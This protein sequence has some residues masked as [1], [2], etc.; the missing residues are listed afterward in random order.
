LAGLVFDPAPGK[1]LEETLSVASVKELSLELRSNRKRLDGE[2]LAL[3][4][5]TAQDRAR[6]EE[7]DREKESHKKRMKEIG[8]EKKT[9]EKQLEDLR[10][11]SAL[12]RE[13]HQLEEAVATFKQRQEKAERAQES[14]LKE[15][16]LKQKQVREELT[17]IKTKREEVEVMMGL[18]KVEQRKELEQL[19][20][21]FESMKKKMAFEKN[22]AQR[23][24]DLAANQQ[25][26]IFQRPLKK[27]MHF[28][29]QING[30]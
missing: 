11:S 20:V 9:L 3:K 25:C 7:I 4:E 23:A 10:N 19:R 15:H 12:I 21:L 26:P 8:A 6:I 13:I 16:A 1:C 17:E 27:R 30:A 24:H 5:Q 18:D 29:P 28:C 22:F 14:L 2:L